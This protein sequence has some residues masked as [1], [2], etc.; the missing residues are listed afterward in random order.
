MQRTRTWTAFALVAALT[1]SSSG[2]ASEVVYNNTTDDREFGLGGTVVRGANYG[3]RIEIWTA[4]GFTVTSSVILDEVWMGISQFRAVDVNDPN[5]DPPNSFTLVIMQGTLQDGPQTV[6]ETVGSLFNEEIPTEDPLLFA[7]DSAKFT[8][9]G[10]TILEAG[11]QYFAVAFPDTPDTN[12][13]WNANFDAPPTGTFLSFRQGPWERA[14][15]GRNLALRVFGS[16]PCEGDIDG[17]GAVDLSDLAALL[18]TFGSTSAVG[19]LTGDGVVDL[20]D[21]ALLLAN[22]GSSC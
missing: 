16:S 19:D 22:F 10:D 6:V 3:P 7:A 8:A 2:L 4:Q 1:A 5:D 12:L 21:L 15:N 17:N 11:V 18:A 13:A 20:S 14:D 9:S